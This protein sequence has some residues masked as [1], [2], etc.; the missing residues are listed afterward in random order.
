MYTKDLNEKE[1]KERQYHISLIGAATCGAIMTGIG[2][3]L[4]HLLIT[5]GSTM[6]YFSYVICLLMF[7]SAAVCGIILVIAAVSELVDEH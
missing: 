4:L 3:I 6:H 2:G 1:K 7:V 5:K